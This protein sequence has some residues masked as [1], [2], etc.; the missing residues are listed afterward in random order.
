MV[1]TSLVG[2][3]GCRR[4]VSF[5]FEDLLAHYVVGSGTLVPSCRNLR[6]DAGEW[7]WVPSPFVPTTSL[8]V[9]G[10]SRP[11]GRETRLPTSGSATL[12]SL[13]TLSG[14]AA[15]RGATTSA[16]CPEPLPNFFKGRRMTPGPLLA[17]SRTFVSLCLDGLVEEGWT[18]Q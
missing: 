18:S 13:R 8:P 9:V 1:Y 14:P 10:R 3:G 15:C 5:R 17:L 11:R 6:G 4:T 16:R 7:W 2:T 12:I